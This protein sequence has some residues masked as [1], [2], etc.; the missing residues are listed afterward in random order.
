MSGG[1]DESGCLAWALGAG[2]VVPE[3]GVGW[4][5]SR[6]RGAAPE[7]VSC[8]SSEWPCG[9]GDIFR[10]WIDL[11]VLSIEIHMKLLKLLKRMDRI[12]REGS[13]E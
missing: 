2:G 1:Q 13:L 11:R 12:K 8:H 6:C 4:P 9:H 7:G 3:L 10:L 5:G